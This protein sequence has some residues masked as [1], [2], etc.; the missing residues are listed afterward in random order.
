MTEFAKRGLI[1]APDFV[2]LKRHNF[3][4]IYKQVFRLIFQSCKY[5][6]R[7]SCLHILKVEI[8][9]ACIRPLFANSI[10]MVVGIN[11]Q[12]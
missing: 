10:I 12:K 3:M 8:L 4:C 7:K 9:D 11:I 1:H 2:T 5:N 6:D